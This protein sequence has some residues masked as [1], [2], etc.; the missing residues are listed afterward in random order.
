M[1]LEIF[2]VSSIANVEPGHEGVTSAGQDA[3]TGRYRGVFSRIVSAVID[4]SPDQSP[5]GAFRL[6]FQEIVAALETPGH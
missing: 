3:L 1:W 5:L 6:V 2:I 4:Q